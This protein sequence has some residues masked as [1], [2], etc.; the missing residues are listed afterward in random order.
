MVSRCR[1]ALT[2]RLRH[3]ALLWEVS[4]WWSFLRAALSR[5]RNQRLLLLAGAYR[6]ARGRVLV[7]RLE[8]RLRPWLE[9]PEAGT[10]RQHRIGWSRYARQIAEPVLTK[11]LILKAP[12]PGGE[13]GVLYVSFEYNWLRLLAQHDP[14]ALLGE[15]LFVGASSWSPPDFAAHWALARI[16]PDP[17]FLQ[18]SNSADEALYQRFRHGIQPVP[19]L[20][21]DWINPAAYQPRRRTERDVDLLMVAGWSPAKRHWLLF[22]ALRRLRPDLRVVLIGQDAD[23]RTV[24]DVWREARL[25]GVHNRIEILRDLP[26]DQVAAH[27][28]RSKVS[29]VLSAREGSCVVTAESLFAD[30]PVV[31]LRDAHIGSRAYINDQTGR[32]LAPDRLAAGLAEILEQPAAFAPRTWALAHI[33]C[34]HATARLN[35]ILRE[36]S[37]QRSRPWTRDLVP[38]CWRPDPIYLSPGDETDLAPAYDNLRQRYGLNIARQPART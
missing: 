17:V 3:S 19:V 27:Q 21:S 18:I 22:R 4:A 26:I 34:H 10:W 31:M 20:A 16:G 30:T 24:D 1:L 12:G 5:D 7:E 11:S 28:C 32:L 8:N 13:K 2:D 9:G 35:S 14:A 25:F 15:Y 6:R 38:M 37:R 23:G 33:T 29:L 36:Y